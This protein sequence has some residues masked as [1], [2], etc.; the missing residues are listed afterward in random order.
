MLPPDGLRT[1]PVLRPLVGLLLMTHVP[2]LGATTL[3]VPLVADLVGGRHRRLQL[4]CP[5]AARR[6]RPLMTAVLRVPAVAREA[7]LRP[8]GIATHLRPG[9]A[10]GNWRCRLGPPH[11]WAVATAHTLGAPGLGIPTDRVV[12]AWEV[13]WFMGG[14]PR[15]PVNAGPPK[16]AFA[17]RNRRRVAAGRLHCRALAGALRRSKSSCQTCAM[18]TTKVSPRPT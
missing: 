2:R 13:G 16:W 1:G 10:S 5:E 17:P 4:C 8:E 15:V 18:Q 11:Q 3:L 9:A 14:G 6:Q 7:D 12:P